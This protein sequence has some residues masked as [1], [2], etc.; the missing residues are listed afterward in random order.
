MGA[1]LLTASAAH[2]GTGNLLVNG[3]AEAAPGAVDGE[4]VPVPGWTTTAGNFTVETYNPDFLGPD[5]TSP[6]PVDRGLNYFA[7]G[8][9]VAL[10]SATQTIDLTPYQD[11]FSNNPFSFTLSGWFG[12]YA[13]QDDNAHLSVSFRDA[14]NNEIEYADTMPVF[15]ADRSSVTGLLFVST[16][17]LPSYNININPASALITL[18]MVRTDGN[19]NDGYADNLSFSVDA[20]PE[21]GSLALMLAGVG[22]LSLLVRRRQRG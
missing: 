6:G 22:S 21:P 12:G 2:A 17:W 10:S 13:S 19:Y 15:A 18:T 7:G 3:S 4:V 11:H 20:V 16:G 14:D 9:D 5:L 8:P 1:A